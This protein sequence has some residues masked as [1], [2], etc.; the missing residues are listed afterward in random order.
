M[1]KTSNMCKEESVTVCGLH[2]CR[3]TNTQYGVRA[4]KHSSESLLLSSVMTQFNI[5]K[6][7][8]MSQSPVAVHI[9]RSR[10]SPQ[11]VQTSTNNYLLLIN[12]CNTISI[13]CV[14]W[15]EHRERILQ[16]C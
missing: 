7:Q 13:V 16:Y 1:P 4:F 9:I 10:F 11:S 5:L 12:I 8:L 2:E 14:D 3:K 15:C 6:Y